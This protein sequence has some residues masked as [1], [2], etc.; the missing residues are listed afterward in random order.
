MR[1]AED[2]FLRITSLENLFAAWDEFKSG[3]LSKVDV[4]R[5]EWQLEPELF[6]LHRELRSGRYRHGP[7]Y[8]FAL[9]D[10]KPRAIHKATVR[11]RIVHHAVF[12]VLNPLFEPSFYWGS[13]SCRVG[14]GTHRGV[15]ALEGIL[16]RVSR[17]YTRPCFVLKC[18]IKKFF[19][20]INHQILRSLLDKKVK[21]DRTR[22][23]LQLLI[24]SFTTHTHTHTHTHTNG[25]DQLDCQSAISPHSFL[26]TSISTSSI[27]L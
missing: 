22:R 17:N 25:C 21:D 19:A 5:F 2:V 4:Q 26:L 18:D 3:K 6:K 8:S 15:L 11:D 12:A 27:T 20:S 23:L 1:L 14:K 7:Y 13:F 16:R 9:R 24:D 10:P